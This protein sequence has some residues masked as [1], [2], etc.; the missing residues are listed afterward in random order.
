MKERFARFACVCGVVCL[1]TLILGWNFNPFRSSEAVSNPQ[2]KLLT[3]ITIFWGWLCFVI[4]GASL[5]VAI[6]ITFRAFVGPKS[7]RRGQG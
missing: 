6:W 4:A 2:L 3:D 5:I 1:V 7:D